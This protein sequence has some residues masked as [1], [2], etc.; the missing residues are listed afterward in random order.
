MIKVQALRKTFTSQVKEP[1]LMGS[2]KGLVKRETKSK[3]ALKSVNLEIQQGEIIGLIGA[4]GAGKTTLVKI[5][6]G[7][8]HPTSGEATVLGYKP[9]ERDNGYRKQMAL[10]MGQKAQVWW[11][12]P[13]LDSFILLKEIYQIEDSLYKKNLEFLADTLQIH[14]QLKVQVRRLSL[15]ERM[16]VELMAA[17]LHNPKVIFLDEPTIGL[18]ISAQKAV[19]EFMKNYQQEFKPITILTSHYMEDIKELCPRIVI[20]KEGEFVYDGALSKVQ[21]LMGDEKVLSVTTPDKNFKVSVPRTDLS[22]KTAE[23]FKSNEVLDLNIHDP[24][25]EDI[26][27]SIM[28]HGM[29]AT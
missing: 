26:I 19:R 3:D 27:E 14:D 21:R 25:I 10:I 1:G 4:N 20:I 7:I 29:K 23:I 15:G 24:S 16:K 9:W 11:D 17:L 22:V 18:D 8:V 2:L 5:L 6:A 13:A 28:K 12:L